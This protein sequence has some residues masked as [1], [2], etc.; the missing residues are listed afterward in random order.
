MITPSWLSWART[1]IGVRE[2]VGAQ[3]NPRVVDYWSIGRVPLQVNDD[4]TS[5]CA[6]FVCAAIEAAGTRSA[7]TPRARGFAD[8][9]HTVPCDARLGAIVVLSSSRGAASGHVGF[10]TGIGNGQLILLGGNQGDRVCEAPF[11]S[12]KLVALRWPANAADWHDYP[13]APSVFSKS[14]AVSDG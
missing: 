6:A 14:G 13:H 4:E 8:S 5:W 1:E 10:L 12:T 9:P 2:I 11:S 7:R 3:H